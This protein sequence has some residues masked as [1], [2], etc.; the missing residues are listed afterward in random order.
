MTYD[1]QTSFANTY[2][3]QVHRTFS[4]LVAMPNAIQLIV[5]STE[6][7]ANGKRYG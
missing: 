2:I 6:Y 4:T 3:E 1:V 7:L 5:I